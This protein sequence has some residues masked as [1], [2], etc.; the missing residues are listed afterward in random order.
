MSQQKQR[1]SCHLLEGFG[2]GLAWTSGEQASGVG[3][4][5]ETMG[6]ANYHLECRPFKPSQK[7]RR[8]FEFGRRVRGP[9]LLETSNQQL[10]R[11]FA[12]IEDDTTGG[13]IVPKLGW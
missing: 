5:Q 4:R 7:S 2:Q 6:T 3:A 10:Q 11:S 8:T 9:C 12:L 1:I 13:G